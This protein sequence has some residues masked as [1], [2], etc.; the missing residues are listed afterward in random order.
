MF[1]NTVHK[2]IYIVLFINHPSPG[3]CAT[4]TIFSRMGQNHQLWSRDD[5]LLLS[6]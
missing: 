1:I 3:L 2:D 5:A 4:R 6:N